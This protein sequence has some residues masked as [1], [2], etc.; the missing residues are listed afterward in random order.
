MSVVADII[1]RLL[2]AP[3]PFALVEG[4]AA[5]AQVKDIPPATPAAFVLP[6][7]DASDDN[8]RATGGH[9][10]RNEADIGVVIIASNLTGHRGAD[11]VEDIETLKTFVRTRL[12][13]WQAAAAV[14]PLGHVSGE[15]V[16][17]R[18]GAVWFEDVF[19]ATTYL[20]ALP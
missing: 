12:T 1:A 10:Q 13:G 17:A 2:V 20:E 4:A 14:A 5:F 16:R 3:T 9:L 7:R 11:A 19:S 15:L 6:L 8:E 18:G